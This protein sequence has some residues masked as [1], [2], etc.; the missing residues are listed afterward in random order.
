[1]Y[2][3]NFGEFFGDQISNAGCILFSHTDKT[4]DAKL[5][6]ALTLVRA[7]NSEAV[8]ITTPAGKLNISALLDAF[9]KKSKQNFEVCNCFS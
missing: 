4:T 6:E 7:K 5:A 3:K 9:E 1:M 2:L 8:I